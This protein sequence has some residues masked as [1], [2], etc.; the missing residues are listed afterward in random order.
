MAS[1]LNQFRKGILIMGISIVQLGCSV[2]G[3]RSEETPRYDVLLKDDNKEIRAYA[4]Y[5]VAK[6]T[7]K[8][9]N[10]RDASGDAFRTLANYIFGGNQGKQSISMTA[11]VTMERSGEG[12]KIAMTAPVTQTKS[13]GGWVM[14]FM[15]PSKYR[16]QDL[17]QPKDPRV[18]FEEVPA[19][20][21]GVL[22]YS[23]TWG[24]EGS[25][26]RQEELKSWIEKTGRYE[27]VSGPA[28]AG[29]DPP[30]TLPFLRRNEVM[31]IV[32]QK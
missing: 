19:R 23:G 12:E 14:T 4:P 2:F 18:Q 15:M 9:E 29:Y 6:T 7:V 3:V 25:G 11:P 16:L 27:V 32:K 24:A 10:Q 17:P 1:F 31:F 5:V 20:I 21:M 13:E 28:F 8:G 22:Q 30:W 26:R